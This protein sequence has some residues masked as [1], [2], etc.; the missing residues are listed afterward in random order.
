MIRARTEQILAF[1]SGILGIVSLS[2][3]VWLAVVAFPQDPVGHFILGFNIAVSVLL[4]LACAILLLRQASG[5][6]KEK[7][8]RE[9]GTRVEGRVTEVRKEPNMYRCLRLIVQ[10]THPQTGEELRLRS[11][12]ARQSSL[13]E[14]D[15]IGVLFDP[16]DETRYVIDMPWEDSRRQGERNGY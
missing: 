15:A 5:R 1:L 3:Y 14:G 12:L 16:M 8:L 6:R 11:A 4:L 13:K 2:I 10:V 9:Y 7:E